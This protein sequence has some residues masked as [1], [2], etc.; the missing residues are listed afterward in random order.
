MSHT[1][2]E[3]IPAPQHARL[4]GKSH[5][6]GDVVIQPSDGA[7]TWALEVLRRGLS[8]LGISETENA[9]ATEPYTLIK[10]VGETPPDLLQLADEAFGADASPGE[11]RPEA[12]VIS[13]RN[14]GTHRTV[15]IAGDGAGQS[16]GADSLLQLVDAT[17]GTLHEALIYDFP[18]VRTRI[19]AG[20][21][22]DDEAARL[23]FNVGRGAT[24][25]DV[26]E[27][28]RCRHL[29][30]WQTAHPSHAGAMKPG[31]CY[32]DAEMVA[33]AIQPLVDA[34]EQG[35]TWLGLNFDDIDLKLGWPEDVERFGT[36]G[37]AHVAFINDTLARL[38][39][40]NPA[41]RLTV[42]PIIYGS[43][44]LAGTWV[45]AVSEDEIYDY[46][47]TLGEAVDPS[48]VF[49]WTGENVES[50][51]MTDADI[52]QWTELVKHETIVF[53][54]TPTTDL[55]DL[56]AFRGRTE[57]IGDLLEGWIYI[58]RGPHAAIAELTTAEF[59]WNPRAYDPDAAQTRAIHRLVGDEAAP[60]MEL[61]I[62]VFRD[63]GSPRYLHP[64]WRE[65]RLLD[66]VDPR[67][68]SVADFYVERLTALGSA[69]PKL[70]VSAGDSP[71][72]Q[73]VR[74]MALSS[75]DVA[76]AF[77][78]TYVMLKSADRGEDEEAIAAGDRAENLYEEWTRHSTG[79]TDLNAKTD[80][81]DA[82][83]YIEQVGV[84][85]HVRELRRGGSEPIPWVSPAPR[86][87]RLGRRC[88]ALGDADTSVWLPV[89][90]RGDNL[91]LVVTGCGPSDA[92][93]VAVVGESEVA[94]PA[95]SWDPNHWR[96]IAIRLPHGAAAVDGI[97]LIA[98]TQ[99]D[100]AVARVACLTDPS[101]GRLLHA[102]RSSARL[103]CAEFAENPTRYLRDAETADVTGRVAVR[104]DVTIMRGVSGRFYDFAA[105]TRIGQTFHVTACGA[106]PLPPVDPIRLHIHES[107]DGDMLCGFALQCQQAGSTQL[108]ATLWRWSGDIDSTVSDESLRIASTPGTL[109]TPHG[110][111]HHICD[112]PFNV[113]LEYGATYYVEVA[114][115]EGWD[116]WRVR[117][118]YGW[119][120]HRSD[121]ERSAYLDGRIE[122]GVDLPF[123]T[124]VADV[125]DAEW[126]G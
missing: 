90:C 60:D 81:R 110:T 16:Y 15:T 78:E 125:Y 32:S 76:Q 5:P 13:V 55:T 53:E 14:H 51:F 4:G 56:G 57:N 86:D 12:Y 111:S 23:R 26:L 94:L 84:A 85:R 54:N 59:L 3:I 115:P 39:E 40:V 47:A 101:P 35:I 18:A 27:A 75:V 77:L 25:P 100:W 70:D 9:P 107:S 67:D 72:Y 43:G 42:I 103:G 46:L 119:Y 66:V 65:G 104:R 114:A 93:I 19:Y 38:R 83:T 8:E 96:S 117:R 58:H 123:R 97:T 88:S 44:W 63:T 122:P 10:L 102:T 41:C 11:A 31:L 2:P 124:Y 6:L 95:S 64:L 98:R 91:W 118:S 108:A 79:T 48:V 74:E 62:D 28:Q 89:V 109:D 61:L 22:G 113:E 20:S 82:L 7:D 45:Y 36:I 30:A 116:G 17:E 21:G 105:E 29:D 33:E 68:A 87:N 92:Q 52:A 37:N 50:M 49:V 106:D 121:P 71:F 99:A 24:T 1:Q 80:R 126:R 34:A 69:L 120:G 112:F 73:A